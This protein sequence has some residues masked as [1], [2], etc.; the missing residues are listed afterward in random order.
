MRICVFLSGPEETRKLGEIL[1]RSLGEG[2]TVALRGDLGA[3]KTSLTQGIAAGLGVSEE[4][5]V[6]S[7]TF[8]L[9]NEYKGRTFLFHIDAYR[10]SGDEFLDTGLDEYFHRPGVTVVEWA[11]RIEDDLPAR[12]LEVELTPERDGRLAVIISRGRGFDGLIDSIKK[13]FPPAEL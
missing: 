9:V 8:V 10:L 3:G 6:V 4:Y 12:R 5:P 7:P 13:V 2:D 1:G 11:E